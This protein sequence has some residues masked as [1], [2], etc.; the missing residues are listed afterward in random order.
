MTYTHVD[1][2]PKIAEF[3]PK[4]LDIYKKW[5]KPIQTHH[6]AFTTMEGMAEFAIQNIL[7]DDTD[8]QNYLTTFMGTDFSSYQVRKSMG[9]DFTQY[10]YVKRGKNTFKTLIENP[11]STQELKNPQIY[12]K[13]IES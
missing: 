1:I 5:L 4:L 2:D 7:K 11:P 9:K 10:V 3:V 8:F 6:A 12:L 13:R